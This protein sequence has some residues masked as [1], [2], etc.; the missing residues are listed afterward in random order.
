MNMK[1]IGTLLMAMILCLGL[2]AACGDGETAQ[3][4]ATTE[5]ATPEYRVTLTDALGAPITSG[6]V[7]K[8]MQNGEQI[9]MQK[10]DA[11]GVAAKT[12]DR[13]EYTV[14]LQFVD[15]D[16]EYKYDASNLKV[17]AEQPELTIVLSVALK[18]ESQTIHVSGVDREAYP[19]KVGTTQVTLNAS[20]RSYFLFTPTE[21]GMYEFSLV[22][23]DAAIGYY[24][25]PHFVQSESA[26][27]VT[28]NKFT[29]SIRPDSIGTG[30]TGTTVMVIGIDAGEG[31]AILCIER[32]GDHEK[33]VEDE[34]WIVYKA[35]M[36]PVAY[37][38]PSG[39]Q[40]AD[41]DLTATHNLVKDADGH[42]HL[43][44][45][46]GPQVFVR[47]GNAATVKYLDPFETILEHTGVNCYFYDENGEFVKKE[48]YGDCLLEYIACVD[49]DSGVYPLND[50]LMYIIQRAGEHNGWWSTKNYIFRDDMGNNVPGILEESAWLF[51]CCYAN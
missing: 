11:N 6:V 3:T 7:V 23:S 19:V 27:E 26:A 14:E 31:E 9:A 44:T 33:T 29:Y 30:N 45:A 2:L 41:F 16:V 46:D 12:L 50:D 10:L 43:N 48:K 25:A 38:L 18:A 4:P 20:E 34:P 32:I 8:F 42:Y 5:N 39:T 47:L 49:E 22:G 40:L 15:S 51:M 35:A 1:R 17:T 37:T 13:G 21:S 24:G 28:D 36:A